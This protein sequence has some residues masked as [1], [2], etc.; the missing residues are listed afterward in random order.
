MHMTNP[1]VLWRYSVQHRP[2]PYWESYRLYRCC[3]ENHRL[4]V[5]VPRATFC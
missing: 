1:A 5:F 4:H 2:T 3:R